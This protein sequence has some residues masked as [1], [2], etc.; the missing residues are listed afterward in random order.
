MVGPVF[1]IATLPL[2]LISY[3]HSA[4]ACAVRTQERPFDGQSSEESDETER[5]ERGKGEMRG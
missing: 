1:L 5:S 4:F 3:A 2:L